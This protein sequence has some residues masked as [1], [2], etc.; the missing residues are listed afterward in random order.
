MRP[1]SVICALCFLPILLEA[2]HQEPVSHPKPDVHLFHQDSNDRKNHVYLELKMDNGGL[3]PITDSTGQ[4]IFEGSYYNG[5][6][7][8]LAWET[9][10]GSVYSSLYRRPR[11]GFGWYTATF[12]NDFTGNPNAIY[13]FVDVPVLYNPK[14]RWQWMYGLALGLS[15]N[16]KPY[17]PEQNPIN[18]A[19]GS[20][21]NSYIN[22]YSEVRYHL[23]P[24]WDIGAGVGFK[25]FSNGSIQRPN[26]GI[27]A[28]PLTVLVQFELDRA[29]ESWQ[30][31]EIPVH[32]KFWLLDVYWGNATKSNE[33]EEGNYWKTV[34][35]VVALKQFC[36]RYRIGF[37]WDFFYAAD[38]DDRVPGTASTF[39]K[40]FSTAPFI[41]WEW[42]I[43]E[44][45][46]L[47]VNFGVYLNRH[48]E[49]DELKPY[50]ERF[51]IRYKINHH[52]ITGVTLKAHADVA[53]MVEWT[54]GYSF[55]K[56][57]N[58]YR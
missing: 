50:Y 30:P 45:L 46:Y 26:E 51:G 8:R 39:S 41:A 19:I 20:R 44:K 10:K 57:P 7:V 14:S 35:G 15:Y 18:Y 34:M 29:P 21:R 31:F 6:D 37:G 12:H 3:L 22:L 23:T 11:F 17:D 16:F 33:Y 13:G 4:N 25:H 28:I 54:V 56:D 55:H 48:E 42:A 40:S 1:I 36:Y 38:S 47:P 5:F 53:D 58:T 49:N 32:Q 9:R 52:F 43:T 24:R 27:N 2:Q